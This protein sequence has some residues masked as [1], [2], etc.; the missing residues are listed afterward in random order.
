MLPQ[1]C[2][3]VTGKVHCPHH[4]PVNLIRL[5]HAQCRFQGTDAG[6]FFTGKGKTR[7]PDPEFSRN[8]ACHDIAQG[9][10]GA[11]GGQGR[12]GVIPQLC[13][14]GSQFFR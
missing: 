8:P 1:N 12:T 10:H 6:I 11:V 7:S 9:A 13:S 5:K 14:P 2:A 4:C 3:Q